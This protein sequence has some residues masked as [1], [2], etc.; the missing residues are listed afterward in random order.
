MQFSFIK[1]KSSIVVVATCTFLCYWTAFG[2]D[3]GVF[4]KEIQLTQ[5]YVTQVDDAD[6]EGLNQW[7]WS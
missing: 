3:G 7:K 4:M 6:Y 5:G 1:S 2:Y